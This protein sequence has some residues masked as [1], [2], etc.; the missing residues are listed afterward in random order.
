MDQDTFWVSVTGQSMIPEGIRSSAFCLVAPGTQARE[1]DR[2]W[3]LDH[4][5]KAA[6]K[7]L[8]AKR[9]N[10]GLGLRGWMPVRDGQ[11]KDFVEER[12]AAGLRE[13]YPVIAVFEGKP[14]S[15]TCS[16]IPDPRPP[17]H[18]VPP[19]PERIPGAITDLP[20]LPE[21]AAVEKVVAAIQAQLASRGTAHATPA[22]A[23]DRRTLERTLKQRRP[24][25]CGRRWQP[26]W[27]RV[28]RLLNPRLDGQ[29]SRLA[30][31]LPLCPTALHLLRHSL[32]TAPRPHWCLCLSCVMSRL[33]QARVWMCLTKPP[34][35]RFWCPPTGCRVRYAPTIWWPYGQLAPQWNPRS[36]A[37]TRLFWITRLQSLLR[38][39]FRAAH[40][41]RP[42]GQAAAAGGRCLDHGQRQSGLPATGHGR[43]GPH[44]WPRPLVWSGEGRC[45][46]RV[47]ETEMMPVRS[48]AIRA[49]G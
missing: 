5:G 39:A 47:S 32:V 23:L 20:G 36:A 42:R 10:G 48:S 9:E 16:Y 15:E 4:E 45:G 17:A 34:T 44:S 33:R 27:T 30:N 7:R 12:F 22:A 40:V 25:H 49:V 41:D 11:Q 35:C 14:G 8:V 46:G 37:A 26:R 13:V 3:V 19:A 21:G 6:I 2:V 38:V 18:A 24:K 29:R 1:G 43:G 28:C 31:L